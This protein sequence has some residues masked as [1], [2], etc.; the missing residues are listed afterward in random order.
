MR[1]T[2]GNISKVTTLSASIALLSACAATQTMIEHGSLDTKTNLSKT[3]FLDPVPKSEKSIYLSIKNTS[4]QEIHIKQKLAN[5]FK[6]KGY[7][8][9]QEPAHAHYMLQANILKVGLRHEVALRTCS[10]QRSREP[11]M[12][13][14]ESRGMNKELPQQYSNIAR[15]GHES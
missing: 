5:A 1:T 4:D 3:I 14:G 6:A 13:L 12:S 11:P 15:L 10:H 2:I 9:T 7:T 8:V